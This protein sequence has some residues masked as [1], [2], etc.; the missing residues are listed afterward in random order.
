MI[1]FSHDILTKDLRQIIN[2]KVSFYYFSDKIET[3]FL[4]EIEMSNNKTKLKP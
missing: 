2:D 4:C 1:Q 3:K